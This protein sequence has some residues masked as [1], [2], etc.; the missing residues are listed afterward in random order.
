MDEL[1]GNCKSQVGK[2]DHSEVGGK[3]CPMKE[4][5]LVYQRQKFVLRKR[6]HWRHVHLFSCSPNCTGQEAGF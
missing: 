3:D 2:W 4:E 6:E 1:V 5:C